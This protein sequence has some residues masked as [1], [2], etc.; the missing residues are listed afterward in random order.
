MGKFECKLNFNILE[1][2]KK[3]KK[4]FMGGVF[5]PHCEKMQKTGWHAQFS[6][7]CSCP[8]VTN[9]VLCYLRQTP[10]D[11]VR[12]LAIYYVNWFS[13]SISHTVWCKC[14]YVSFIDH[15]S[16]DL[17]NSRPT[18]QLPTYTT[19]HHPSPTPSLAYHT[20]YCFFQH[21]T[22]LTACGICPLCLYSHVPCGFSTFCTLPR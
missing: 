7:A 9:L 19:Q 3:K 6:G 15:L 20:H 4:N 12:V 5:L 11:I 16:L 17:A 1:S 21:A 8:C 2:W 18:A 10:S 14:V 13:P 22:R